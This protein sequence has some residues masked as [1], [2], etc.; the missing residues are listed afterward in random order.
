MVEWPLS[1]YA[2]P[3]STNIWGRLRSARLLRSLCFILQNFAMVLSIAASA[4]TSNKIP[5]SAQ[6]GADEKMQMVCLGLIDIT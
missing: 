6:R 4:A 5:Q 1:G 3:C 2:R